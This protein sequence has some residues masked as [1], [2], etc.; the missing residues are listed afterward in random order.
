M[1]HANPMM[2]NKYKK[3]KNSQKKSI[4]TT[5]NGVVFSLSSDKAAVLITP[6]LISFITKAI[7]TIKWI[8]KKITAEFILPPF[9]SK[10]GSP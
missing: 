9:K 7:K 1:L 2:S 5:E 6:I 8:M 4:K 3:H 10:T